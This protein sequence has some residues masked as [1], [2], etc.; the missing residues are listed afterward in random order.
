MRSHGLRSWAKP[1]QRQTG[2]GIPLCLPTPS[3]FFLEL[4][5]LRDFKSS[6]FGN[7]HSAGVAEEHLRNCLFFWHAGAFAQGAFPPREIASSSD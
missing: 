6:N 3:P 1:C 2:L 7:I 5:I 4:F